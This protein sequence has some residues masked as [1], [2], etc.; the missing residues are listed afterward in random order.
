MM[1]RSIQGSVWQRVQEAPERT[2]IVDAAGV[3]L[4]YAELWALA[5][6]GA[7]ALRRLAGR[8]ATA[9]TP[10][11][12]LPQLR[13]MVCVADGWQ[14]PVL[15]LAT[16]LADGVVVPASTA[17]PPARLAAVLDDSEC[18]VVVVRGALDGVPS[19]RA[20]LALSARPSTVLSLREIVAPLEDGAFAAADARSTGELARSRT[21]SPAALSP[22]AVDDASRLCHMI[23]TSGSTGVPKG[24][25]VQHSALHA[26]VRGWSERLRI[27]A[28]SRVLIAS[29]HTF[30]PNIGN[31][32]AALVAGGAVVT[33]ARAQIGIAL[34]R[35]LLRTRATHVCLTPTTL[36]MV[37]ES[38]ALFLDLLSI[39]V[40]GEAMGRGLARRWA[41]APRA[42]L[43]NVY[44]A[45][46]VSVLLF[47]VTFT[48]ILLTV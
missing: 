2:A 36:A 43:F 17:A 3:E 31:T 26:F 6:R 44:G 8:R 35:T 10:Q 13:V 41:R 45:T 4:S 28:A 32:F 11:T 19:L 42:A 1:D 25:L 29:A 15:M 18:D 21:Q 16:L 47:T 20:A 37:D 38:P 7:D 14:L 33:A 30:D 48:R 27:G 34:G 5:S 23:Y 12:P 22:P 46:E 9:G 39:Q 40:G 24:V